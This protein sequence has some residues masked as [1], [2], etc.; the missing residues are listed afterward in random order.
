[1]NLRELSFEIDDGTGLLLSSRFDY[2][3]IFQ[4]FGEH[5][6]VFELSTG[7]ITAHIS[8]GKYLTGVSHYSVAFLEIN[9]RSL[10]VVATDWNRLDIIDPSSGHCLTGRS[11]TSHNEGEQPPKHYLDYFHGQLFVSPKGN[12]IVDNGWVWHPIG[13]VRSW[14][15]HAWLNRNPWE[16]EDGPSLQTLADWFYFMNGPVCWIDDSTIAIWGWGSD[17]DWLIPAVRLFDLPSGQE[18]RWFPGPKTRSKW[19]LPRKKIAP[20]MFFDSYL[21]SIHDDFGTAVWDVFSGEQLLQDSSL[22]PV[23]YHPGSKEFLSVASDGILLSTL[24]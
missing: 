5:A 22:N 1:M 6:C 16:S 12:W 19:E 11:P 17:D 9:E 14:N 3:V 8:R 18:T 21:F 7:A 13:L 24:S 4:T 2:G 15:L 23:Q 10:I 20:S